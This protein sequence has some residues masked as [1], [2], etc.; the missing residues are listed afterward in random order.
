MCDRANDRFRPDRCAVGTR[1]NRKTGN[2]E[3]RK[4]PPGAPAARCDFALSLFHAS[5]EHLRFLRI[6]RLI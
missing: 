3:L 4:R 1:S 5:L 2:A 6:K